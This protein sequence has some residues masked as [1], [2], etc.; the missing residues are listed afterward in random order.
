MRVN[1]AKFYDLGSFTGEIADQ[2][3]TSWEDLQ[4]NCEQNGGVYIHYQ[5]NG[6]V[7]AYGMKDGELTA[8]VSAKQDRRCPV[9]VY[10]VMRDMLTNSG[11]TVIQK[12]EFMKNA[13]AA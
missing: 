11:I 10:Y 5:G 4:D 1:R 9:D 8:L 6:E 13:G 3:E 12:P 7:V 2:I